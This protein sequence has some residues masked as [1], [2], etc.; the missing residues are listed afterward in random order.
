MSSALSSKAALLPRLGL[1]V[2][3]RIVRDDDP[4]SLANAGRN[5]VIRQRTVCDAA[6]ERRLAV[7]PSAVP[8]GDAG[9]RHPEGDDGLAFR[10]SAWVQG[11]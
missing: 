4:G 8:L 6:D 11:L 7:L 9:L 2:V 3:A 1:P 10:L 5:H